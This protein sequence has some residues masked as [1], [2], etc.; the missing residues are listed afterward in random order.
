MKSLREEIAAEQQ[1]GDLRSDLARALGQ[2]AQA[3]A[4]TRDLVD[5]AYRGAFDAAKALALPPQKPPKADTRRKTPETAVAVLADWQLGKKTPSYGSAIC[6]KRIAEYA[7]RVVKLTAIQR[8]DH[9]VQ[10]LRV[11]LLG[12][13]VEG[14]LIF[15][16]QAHLI[17][18]SLFVQV[19]VDGPRI[20]AGFIRRMLGEFERVHVVG[21]IGNHGALGGQVRRDYHPESN[22]DAFLYEFTRRLFANE[23]RLTWADN[24]R[25]GERKWYA[26]DRIGNKGYLLFHGDQVKGGFAGFP[27]YGFGKKIM[28]WRMGAIPEPFDY[29]L[30]GHFHTPV[31]GLYGNVRHWG[32]GSPES[33][34]TYA[35]ERLAAQ[36]TPSQ[37]LLF[38]HPDHGVTAEYEV[39][40]T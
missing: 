29:A 9:P 26:V 13:I 11:Y 17:D 3:K 16:G 37:W 14:E 22:A 12:D 18:A 24:L 31:R 40:L 4:K 33:D 8:A 1:V 10:T 25:S 39:H 20:L 6:E 28:G 23:P 21:V 35:A 36:G 15:P 32:S 7:E 5:A 2:L 19:M 34:N 38:A 27:W 30:S